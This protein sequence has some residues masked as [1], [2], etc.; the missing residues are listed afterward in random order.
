MGGASVVTGTGR[1]PLPRTRPAGANNRRSTTTDQ[2]RRR[3]QR[4]AVGESRD[5]DETRALAG[6]INELGAFDVIITNAGEYGLSGDEM[7]NANSLSP[8]LLTALVSAPAQLIYLNSDLHPNG[9]LKPDA[10][11]SGAVT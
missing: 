7:L 9:D 3:S 11:R 5:L 6:Q 1:V 10:L 2:I 4:N 8:Y